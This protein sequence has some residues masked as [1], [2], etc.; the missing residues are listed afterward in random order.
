MLESLALRAV[1]A[2][3]HY[4]DPKTVIG[5]SKYLFIKSLLDAHGIELIVD[6]GGNVGQFATSMRKIGYRGRI[7]SFEPVAAQFAQIS[8][9]ARADPK[10]SVYN[11]ALGNRAGTMAIN[12]MNSSVFSSF[13]QPTSRE[14]D[15]FAQA[16]R[17]ER[18]ET[19]EVRTLAGMA[20]E[21][22]LV[23]VL[24][25]AFLKCD[26][27]GFDR[28]VLIGAGDLLAQVRL[29]QIELSVTP[30]YENAP[31]MTEMLAFV[32]AHGFVPVASFPIN[33][34]ADGSAA[35][36]DYLGV[37]RRVASGVPVREPELAFA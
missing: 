33:R 19:V 9:S 18:V 27:Q 26:T 2:L 12:V 6:V 23:G 13:R 14:T 35:E 25:R 17:I 7:I 4:I 8:R 30:I 28:E 22:E 21:L 1:R 29:L 34:L 36:L 10:W 15:D 31:R 5:F 3:G 11:M 32:E 37:N 24:N 16:N 20:E